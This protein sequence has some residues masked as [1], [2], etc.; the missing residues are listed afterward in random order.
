[1]AFHPTFE[2]YRAYSPVRN[3]ST[4]TLK[5]G[6]YIDS[7]SSAVEFDEGDKVSFSWLTGQLE[8]NI[9]PGQWGMARF[10]TLVYRRDADSVDV[11]QE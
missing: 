11:P 1:M 10:Y 6:S 3:I 4:K 8:E 5:R 7:T 2:P 9:L